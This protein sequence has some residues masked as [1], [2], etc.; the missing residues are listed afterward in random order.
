[1]YSCCL[2]RLPLLP[3]C[4]H[5]KH[6]APPPRGVRVNEGANNV[7]T[8]VWLLQTG[9]YCWW[10]Q[11]LMLAGPCRMCIANVLW[12]CLGVPPVPQVPKAVYAQHRLY[13]SGALFISSLQNFSPNYWAT[14]THIKKIILCSWTALCV[15]SHKTS[16]ECCGQFRMFTDRRQKSPEISQFLSILVFFLHE[17]FILGQCGVGWWV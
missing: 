17:T 14:S 9:M 13:Y 2:R 7:H 16:S 15:T 12:P 8:N 10:W 4:K 1:M 3:Q 11:Q 6:L 5:Q